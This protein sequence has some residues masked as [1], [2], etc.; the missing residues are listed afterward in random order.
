LKTRSFQLI[1]R[2]DG[3]DAK[4][5]WQ[6]VTSWDGV[7]HEMAPFIRMTHPARFRSLG[8]IPANGHCHFVSVL[9][10]L[11]VI[12]IDLHRLAFRAF[13]YG[14]SFSERS[15]NFMMRSWSHDRSVR[16]VSDGV[17]IR[18]VCAFEP[19]LLV[20]GILLLPIYRWFFS[21]RHR[22]LDRFFAP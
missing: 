10:F 19:R 16:S 8:D 22:R 20:P 9:L 3:V 17:T 5:V 18:D 12:P 14:H 21:R 13:D 7:N 6:R 4:Q 11:G 2:I 1:S 15:S